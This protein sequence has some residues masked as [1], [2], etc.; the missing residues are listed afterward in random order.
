M[1]YLFKIEGKT[2]FPA[3][4]T[5]MTEP[6]KS[7]WARDKNKDKETALK[8]FAYIEFMVSKLASNPYKGYSETVRPKIIV[9]DLFE[10]KYKPDD[11]VK[12]GIKKLADFQKNSS[13]N[14]SLYLN[15]IKAKETLEN[16]LGTVDL[17][18][19]N[20]KTGAPMY[21]PKEISSSLLDLDKVATSLNALEK[22][23]EEELY[24]V[25]KTKGQKEISPFAK[26]E[27]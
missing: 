24:D 21:K 9:E 8:E 1:A 16:F 3:E 19:I 23:I 17:Q 5:L 20:F 4:E 26:V 2:V 11:L 10:G 12:A 13:P 6:F 22:K 15:A 18:K 14:Y 27:K 25:M 7:I